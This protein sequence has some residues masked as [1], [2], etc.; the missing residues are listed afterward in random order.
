MATTGVADSALV[1][2]EVAIKAISVIGL[3]PAQM[4]VTEVV[5]WAFYE[6]PFYR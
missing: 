6:Q 2:Q 5:L 4:Q 3:E 1:E